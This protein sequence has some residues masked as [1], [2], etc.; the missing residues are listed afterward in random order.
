MV[1]ISDIKRRHR[2]KNIREPLSILNRNTPDG[3]CDIVVAS[4]TRVALGFANL[5]DLGT[6]FV[7]LFT[8]GQEHR[9]NARVLN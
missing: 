8:E 4:Y 5:V 2:R 6:N 7:L 1:A 3:V 9:F